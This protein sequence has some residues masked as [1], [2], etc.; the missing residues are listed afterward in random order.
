MYYL[1]VDL[2]GTNIKSGLVDENGN[3]LSRAQRPTGAHRGYEEI[4]K[5]ISFCALDAA[6]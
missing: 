3:I 1:A 6:K 4:A 2:G 5:D